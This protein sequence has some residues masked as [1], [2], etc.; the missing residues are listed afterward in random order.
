MEVPGDGDENS[1]EGDLLLMDNNERLDIYEQSHQ[2]FRDAV[3]QLA[4]FAQ[5]AHS[6]ET[7]IGKIISLLDSALILAIVIEPGDDVKRRGW[8]KPYTGAEY[9]K[10]LELIEN[11]SRYMQMVQKLLSDSAMRHAISS[12]IRRKKYQVKTRN[13][14][15]ER[16]FAIY[17]ELGRIRRDME[18]IASA[19][20][21]IAKT[22]RKTIHKG[23]E[24]EWNKYQIVWEAADF[25]D[26][27][28]HYKPSYAKTSPFTSFVEQIFT[29][30]FKMND[31]PDLSRTIRAA[32]KE[33]PLR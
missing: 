3:Y 10:K 18:P 6:N 9:N 2:G 4:D 20:K 1:T 13:E 28:G 23:R 19:L 29:F 7:A 5:I 11:T 15:E 17:N 26:D 24:P 27:N 32:L 16:F 14:L 21:S 25:F 33:R 8:E 22:A 30:A 12:E 31:C